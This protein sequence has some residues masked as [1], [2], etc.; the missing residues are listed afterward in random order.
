MP[1]YKD[2]VRTAVA[3]QISALVSL[4][5]ERLLRPDLGDLGFSKE[6][7]TIDR[8]RRIVGRLQLCDLELLSD[9]KVSQCAQFVNQLNALFSKMNSF[10]PGRANT[11]PAMERNQILDQCARVL[12]ESNDQLVTVF[13]IASPTLQEIDKEIR[14]I[15]ASATAD[16]TRLLD[17]TKAEAEK[18]RTEIQD[19]LQSVRA[20][21]GA[22]GIEK[23]A[24][25]FQ[26]AAV[27]S[28]AG[29]RN[30]LIT[31]L[32]LGAITVVALAANWIAAYLLGPPSSPVALVQISVAKVL[33][34]SFLISAVLWSG[35]IYRSYEHNYVLNKHRQNALETFQLFARGAGDPE[36][37]SM[38]LLQATKSIFSNQPTGFLS[39]E[40]DS[41]SASPQILEIIRGLTTQNK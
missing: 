12:N 3:A 4:E 1:V 35:K 8:L 14:L 31:T 36:T 24:E 16:S 39:G 28:A 13:A 2:D 9:N 33:V 22:I 29:R 40:R 20:A 38:V 15:L 18:A 34:F 26:N 23:Q 21:T 10:S 6:E 17:Q 25:V 5:R 30:W 41:E 7:A 27:E 37:K 11:A 32:V 19:T